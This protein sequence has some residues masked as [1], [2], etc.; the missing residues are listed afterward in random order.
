MVRNNNLRIMHTLPRILL[1]EDDRYVSNALAHMLRSS[2]EIDVSQSGK[3]ALYKADSY[4]YDIV[5]LDLN[6]PDISGLDVCK[7]LRERGIKAP[8]LILSGESKV[9]T[10]VNLLD[11]GANDYLTKPFSLGE[12]QARIRALLRYKDANG[13]WPDAELKAC[14][15]TLNRRTFTVERDSQAIYL[16]R[17]EFELLE[18][19]MEQAN[20]LVTRK[21]LIK[22]V[23]NTTEPWANTIDV[24]IK[25]L[26]DKIDKPFT[27]PLIKTIHGRGYIFND[28][29]VLNRVTQGS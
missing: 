19:L 13:V 7:Q 18:C 29:P 27:L 23:W 14:G 2:Y 28:K 15:I 6:L 10:K 4:K 12:L 9:L 21:D 20:N 24:H 1:V 11:A 5:I 25:Y 16:R 17:K 22:R 26:R 8:I 3:L